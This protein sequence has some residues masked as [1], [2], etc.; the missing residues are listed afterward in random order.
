MSRGCPYQC[1]YCVNSSL[2]AVQ[3]ACGKY[4]RYQSP[5]TTIR[6]I[7]ELCT[8]HGVSWFKFAD[9]S[10]CYFSID[11]LEELRDGLKGLNIM[12][13]CSI[14]PESITEEKIRILKDMGLVAASVGV[15]SGNPE[16]R[17]KVLYRNMTDDQ[18]I[19]SINLLHKYDV[20]V[21]TFNMIGLPG[22][23]R[24]DVFSTIRIN[25]KARVKATNVYIIYPYPGTDICKKYAGDIHLANGEL[26]PVSQASSFA[27]SH[28]P[29]IEV[30]GLLKTFELYVRLPEK[31][32]DEVRE[33]EHLGVEE[34]IGHWRNVQ[35]YI[36]E[37]EL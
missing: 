8:K 15:E 18:I 11:Y 14:R 27:L 7:T 30:E 29:P 3:K 6:H 28:M 4:F 2:K 17:K 22:E 32:W 36:L 37:N 25:R 16:I 19:D 34:A 23:T 33:I 10:I 9:D 13:G 5:K 12:F 1:S 24:E 21:S 35:Q 31:K 26:I 20:R